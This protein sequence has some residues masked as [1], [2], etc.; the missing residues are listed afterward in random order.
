MTTQISQSGAKHELEFW[1]WFV[2]T[3]RFLNGWVQPVVTNELQPLV[4]EAI[5]SIPGAKVLDAGSGV[6]SILHGL[7]PDHK[8]TATDPLSPE[9]QKFFDYAGHGIHPPLPIAAED[10]DFLEKFQI[11]HIRNAID[12][13]NDP[14]AA[15]AALW[16]AVAP[17]GLL[18][19]HG[20][21]NE[22][23]FENRAGF[24][25]WNMDLIE[26]DLCITGPLCEPAL[27]AT[28]AET[29]ARFILETG[30][31]WITWIKRK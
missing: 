28:D 27:V 14:A 22:A 11:V 15:Y 26:G 4:I 31:E 2:T 5:R 23:T 3:D 6:V 12:H 21:A 18:I 30:R 9:F 17:G 1:R 10:I 25:Q 19:V 29:V 20:F 7:V 8:L 24:H 13:T 16:R